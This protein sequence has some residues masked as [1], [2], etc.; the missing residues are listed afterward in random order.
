MPERGNPSV[1]IRD[2]ARTVLH[3]MSIVTRPAYKETSADLAGHD[4]IE[5]IFKPVSGLRGIQTACNGRAGWRPHQRSVGR[6]G[7]QP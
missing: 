4:R 3:E 1:M 2:I 6:S 7:E 5:R